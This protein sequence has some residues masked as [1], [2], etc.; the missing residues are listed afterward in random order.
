MC[1]SILLNTHWGAL[2]TENSGC[3]Q[4]KTISLAYV[5]EFKTLDV[6]AFAT[7]VYKVYPR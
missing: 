4:L 3:Y 5:L 6:F 2:N 7:F 1:V